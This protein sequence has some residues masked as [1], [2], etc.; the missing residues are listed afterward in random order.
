MVPLGY[1]LQLLKIV[2]QQVGYNSFSYKVALYL[3]MKWPETKC[4]VNQISHYCKIV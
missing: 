3:I 1:F 2:I 4:L